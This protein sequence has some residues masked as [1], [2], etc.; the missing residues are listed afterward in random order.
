M[1]FLSFKDKY[2][3][4][5]YQNI[6]EP[7]Q[8]IHLIEINPV[9]RILQGLKITTLRVKRNRPRIY[10]VRQGSYKKPIIA[11]FR[12]NIWKVE[13]RKFNSLSLQEIQK[14]IGLTDSEF[15]IIETCEGDLGD[16]MRFF[17]EKFQKISGVKTFN[18][19]STAYL[20]YLKVNH[21]NEGNTLD[22]FVVKRKGD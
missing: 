17:L 20:H 14:D 7:S 22:K 16:M 5:I 4:E 13:P 18:F 15:R 10:Q 21:V 11:P 12:V 19:E 1:K 3:F 2:T 9:E 8:S 6:G